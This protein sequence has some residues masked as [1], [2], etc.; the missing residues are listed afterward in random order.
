MLSLKKSSSGASIFSST[1]TP[2]KP[3]FSKS[4]RFLKL[5]TSSS[6]L[7]AE[8]STT[9]SRH[10]PLQGE[11]RAKQFR[12]PLITPIASTQWCTSLKLS[13]ALPSSAL[14]KTSRML[15]TSTTNST[16]CL[17]RRVSTFVWSMPTSA[18]CL[19]RQPFT[20]SIFWKLLPQASKITTTRRCCPPFRP[21]MVR[22]NTPISS[23]SSS[24][25]TTPTTRTSTLSLR[26]RSTVTVPSSHSS[27]LTALLPRTMTV[28]F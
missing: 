28:S 10:R 8:I 27:W 1:Q 24:C 21:Q 15:T 6:R 7:R 20:K 12:A 13:N 23:S 2:L 4:L 22:L 17:C 3:R 9:T 14:R 25:P 11:I 18:Q 19:T 5:Q 16:T 26:T